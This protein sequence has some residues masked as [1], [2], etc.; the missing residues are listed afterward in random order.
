MGLLVLT[1]VIAAM[2]S[3]EAYFAHGDIGTASFYNPPYIQ[4]YLFFLFYLFL[5]SELCSNISPVRRAIQN[6]NYEQFNF[7][8]PF[9]HALYLAATKCDG[10]REEQFPPGNLFVAVDGYGTMVLLVGGATD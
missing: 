7:L 3:K 2:I 4:D 1:I 5:Y 6:L 10:N 9:D 8:E